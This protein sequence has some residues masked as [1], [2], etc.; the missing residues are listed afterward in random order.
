MHCLES[1]ADTNF[2]GLSMQETQGNAVSLTALSLRETQVNA[3]SLTG[4]SLRVTQVN[5]VSILQEIPHYLGSPEDSILRELEMPHYL[6]SP[7]NSIP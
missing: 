4:L 6:G 1:P 7:A 5:A 3:V 2:E